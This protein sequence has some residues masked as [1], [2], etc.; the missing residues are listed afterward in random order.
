MNIGAYG[1][2]TAVTPNIDA[3]AKEGVVFTRAYVQFASC[4]ASRASMLTGM[5]PDSIQVWR[6]NSHFRDTAPDVVTLP[7]H[8]RNNGYHTE[9]VGKIF[10]NYANIRDEASW[11]VPARLDQENHFTDYALA[12]SIEEG[13]KIGIAAE[14]AEY[15]GDG[16]VDDRITTDAIETLERLKKENK[17]FFLAVGFMKPHS[18]YNAPKKYWEL[19]RRE[20]MQALGSETKPEDVPGRNWFRFKEIRDLTDLPDKGSF[21]DET[22]KRLRHGYYAATSYMDNNV[23]RIIRA[24]KENSLYENTI[25]IFLSDH[26][27]H[28]GENGHWTKATVREL[29]TR[30][31][32]IFRIPEQS[33]FT[34]NAI[35]E[36]IDIYPTVSVLA[37]LPVPAGLDG[38]SFVDIFSNPGHKPKFAAYSQTA[39][40]WPGNKPITHMGYTVRTSEFRYTR[41]IKVKDGRMVA[42]ELYHTETDPLER[43]NLVKTARHAELAK[44]RELLR[45]Q[46]ITQEQSREGG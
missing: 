13:E 42:E 20:D 11:S 16:Y 37:G 44:M 14:N 29:D 5:R 12:T 3:L 28:L 43:Q 2:K 6:L 25:I 15:K 1:D 26:G 8:F 36:F 21:S 22:K 23:G 18:P 35:T 33:A 17:P 32:L 45:D 34:T 40:P 10:H 31:P 38:K 41:W 39:R 19:Y 7:Q 9:S 27:Y 24:L 4:N 46:D 30:S